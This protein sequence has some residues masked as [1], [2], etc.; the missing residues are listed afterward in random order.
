MS[1]VL[2]PP[3]KIKIVRPHRAYTAPVTI[4]NPQG[5]LA[6][7]SV[8]SLEMNRGI[9]VCK[10]LLTLALTR[11]PTETSNSVSATSVAGTAEDAIVFSILIRVGV[12]G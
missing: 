4:L 1:D 11:G 7:M 10:R 2:L 8:S 3:H 6:F 9:L 12:Y 5:A